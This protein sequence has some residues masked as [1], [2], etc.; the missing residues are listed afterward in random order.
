MKV[1]QWKLAKDQSDPPSEINEE[2]DKCSFN[3]LN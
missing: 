2:A 1:G 3:V